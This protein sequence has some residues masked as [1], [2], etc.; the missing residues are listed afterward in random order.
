MHFYESTTSGAEPRHYVP[1]KTRPDELRPTTMRDV[2]AWWN[3]G[4]HVVPSVTTV[5]NVLN[6]PG[7]NNWLIDQHIEQAHKLISDYRQRDSWPEI[8]TFLVQTKS[9]ARQAMN[10]APEAGKDI[11]ASLESAINRQSVSDEHF[12]ICDN[13]VKVL[14][15]RCGQQTWSTEQCFAAESYGGCIDLVSPEWVIDY[16]SKQTADKFK[17]GKMVYDEHIMQLAAYRHGFGV[18]ARAANVFVCLETG[19]VDFH[20]HTED[21]LNCGW[22]MFSHALAIWKLQNRRQ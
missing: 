4:K 14:A 17:P 2:R 21:E 18:R 5:L 3:D 7:L 8:D 19:E 13:V 11:H 10:E 15:D 1:M 9:W 16:K 6:K 20:E 12:L 22:S